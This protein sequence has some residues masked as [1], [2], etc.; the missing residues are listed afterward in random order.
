MVPRDPSL[1]LAGYRIAVPESRQL[2]V[3]EGLL[4]R[5]G[6]DVLRCPLVAIIDSPDAPGV[7]TWLREFI[8]D[9]PF[10]FILL[11]GEGLRRLRGF[12]AGAAIDEKGFREALAA[13]EILS[14]GPKPARELRGYDLSPQYYA[15]SP[16]TEGVIETLSGIDVGGR[17]VAVQLYGDDPNR[18]LIDYLEE[19]GAV[20][21]TVAPYRYAPEFSDDQIAGLIGELERAAVAGVV[22]TSKSQVDRLFEVARSTGRLDALQRGL[23]RCCVA[24]IGPVVADALAASQ[25]RVDVVPEERFFMKPLVQSLSDWFGGKGEPVPRR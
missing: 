12:V 2:D 1:P 16:T 9:P 8:D 10:L 17:T 7:E 20:V 24:A 25:C 23:A 14:R 19:R 5:R 11:T 13:T 22:F 21:S 6:A 15:A 4:V 3:L 18:R